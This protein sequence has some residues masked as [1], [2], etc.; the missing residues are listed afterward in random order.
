MEPKS[1]QSNKQGLL[2]IKELCKKFR[3]LY[4]DEEIDKNQCEATLIAF[5]ILREGTK[6]YLGSENQI[7]TPTKFK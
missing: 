7:S 1:K 5:S 3:S 6:K 4:F 2:E